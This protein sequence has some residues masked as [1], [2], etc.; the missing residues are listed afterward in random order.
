MTRGRTIWGTLLIVLAAS[1]SVAAA[2]SPA[3]LKLG[4]LFPLTG[5][6]AQLAQQEYR[7][8]Q[9]A[10]RLVNSQ[11][12][13]GGRKIELDTRVVNSAQDAPAQVESLV[14]DGVPAIIGTYSSS[15]SI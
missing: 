3:P 12:G 14:G 10:Q 11:G 5:A 2:P 15:L 7:G 4:A 13:V 9:I 6:T 8:V 1:T